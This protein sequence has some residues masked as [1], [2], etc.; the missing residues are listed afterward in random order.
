MFKPPNR[1]G[2]GTSPATF[3][4]LGRDSGCSSKNSSTGTTRGNPFQSLGRDSGCSSS[5]RAR[6]RHTQFHVSIPRSGFWVFK[7]SSG[8]PD[9]VI[10]AVSIPRSGFW[11]FKHGHCHSHARLGG[12][13]NPSVGILGVQAKI[14]RHHAIL[15]L[16]FQSLGRDSGCSSLPQRR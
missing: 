13:F 10:I 11:V 8:Q 5:T 16:W 6:L 2:K 9:L 4:S 3:Q 7:L 12:G 1:N 15:T 14:T